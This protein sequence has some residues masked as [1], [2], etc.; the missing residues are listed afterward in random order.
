MRQ[1]YSPVFDTVPVSTLYH[2]TSLAGLKEIVEEQVL[3]A[4]N[5]HYMSDMKEIQH[6]QDF[7]IADIMELLPSA[8]PYEAQVL[9]DLRH[10][11]IE[12]GVSR[13]QLFLCSFTEEGNLL[14]QWRGYTPHGL[15][16]SLGFPTA[17]IVNLATAQGYRLVQCIYDPDLQRR[18]LSSL[19]DAIFEA[20]RRA[21]PAREQPSP[22]HAVFETFTDEL[23]FL[24]AVLKHSSF[25][26]E[27]EWRVISP[28]FRDLHD[29]SVKYRIGRFTLIPYREFRITSARDDPVRIDE[30]IVGPSSNLALS[31]HSIPSY[32]ASQ[33]VH[34]R[35]GVHSCGIP[36]RG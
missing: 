7:L 36:Y 17:D 21:S 1:S 22:F 30:V 9:G 26:E 28:V 23:L 27:R 31:M 25:R 24:S 20:A 32:L 35:R 14:S 34:P 33:G 18:M 10:W 12:G 13:H 16:V 29:P 3:W 15:G 11:L 2:Y 19:M 6:A 4:S 5:A 8:E